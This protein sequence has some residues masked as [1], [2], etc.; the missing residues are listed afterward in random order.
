MTQSGPVPA[1]MAL[2]LRR[3]RAVNVTH[4]VAGEPAREL[5]AGSVWIWCVAGEE[6]GRI[7]AHPAVRTVLSDAEWARRDR[8][9]VEAD[10][11]RFLAARVLLRSMLAAGTGV[12]AGSWGFDSDGFGRPYIATPAS[13]TGLR[14]SITHTRGLVAC[15]VTGCGEVGLDAEAYDRATRTMDVAR[16]FFSPKEV[17]YLEECSPEK[18]RDA[19][20]DIWTLKEAYGKALGQGLSVPLDRFSFDLSA[21]PPQLPFHTELGDDPDEWAFASGRPTRR[22]SMAVAAR[23]GR[24]SPVDLEITFATADILGTD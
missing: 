8:L 17:V 21:P 12:G 13:H 24:L 7:T 15:A 10:R 5:G 22:H 2:D 14:F 11:E 6:I 18:H 9:R 19:F 4:R 3:S 20:F 16:R 23:C 1:D